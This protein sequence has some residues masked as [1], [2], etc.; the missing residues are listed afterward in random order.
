MADR[1]YRA[2]LSISGLGFAT[3]GICP[4]VFFRHRVFMAVVNDLVSYVGQIMV[5]FWLFHVTVLDSAGVLWIMAATSAAAVGVGVW[6][7]GPIAWQAGVQHSILGRHW[8]FS[9]WLTVSTALQWITN[10]VFLITAGGVLGSASVGG[11]KAGQTLLGATHIW[12]QGLGNLVPARAAHYLQQR[13]KDALA[14]YL[15]RVGGAVGAVTALFALVIAVAPVWWLR[16]IYG[17]A[18]QDYGGIVRWQAA[19]YV[20]LA[21]GFPLGIGLRTFEKTHAIFLAQVCT[22]LFSLLFAIPLAYGLRVTGVVMG[23]FCQGL[24]QLVIFA[25]ELRK[26]FRVNQQRVQI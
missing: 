21:I 11:L 14:Q 12:L 8:R 17:T 3:P 5:L 19:G 7:I 1:A 16:L 24:L 18:Y 2:S 15:W 25:R 13:G 10:N 26:E 4:S 23:G 22:M 6:F 9:R 20:A